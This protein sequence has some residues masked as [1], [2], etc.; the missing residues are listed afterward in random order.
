MAFMEY[1]QIL[2]SSKKLSQKECARSY[3]LQAIDLLRCIQ[4]EYGK[5]TKIATLLFLNQANFVEKLSLLH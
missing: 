2:K 3:S 5:K 1:T 4:L